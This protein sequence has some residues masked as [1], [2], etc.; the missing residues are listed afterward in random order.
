[1]LTEI[2]LSHNVPYT[3]DE[4]YDPNHGLCGIQLCPLGRGTPI[5]VDVLVNKYGGTLE[6]I[7]LLFDDKDPIVIW[8]Q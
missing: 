2:K 5:A 6:Y 1:M 7:R 8:K 4:I 3:L